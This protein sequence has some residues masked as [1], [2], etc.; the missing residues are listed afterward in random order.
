MKGTGDCDDYFRSLTK[1]S[2]TFTLYSSKLRSRRETFP[3]NIL[4]LF[5]PQNAPLKER[6]HDNK[7]KKEVLKANRF[8]T[9]THALFRQLFL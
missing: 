4:P 1:F 9:F 2:R 5:C 8:C 6:N 3:D 7:A